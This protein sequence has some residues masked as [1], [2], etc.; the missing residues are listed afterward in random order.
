MRLDGIRVRNFR[1]LRRA[2]IDGLSSA[3]LVTVSGPNGSGK[4]LLFEALGFLARWWRP[5]PL[6]IDLS[7]LLGP[8]GTECEL[9]VTFSLAESERESL[10]KFAAITTW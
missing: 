2:E 9:V 1:G 5:P 10:S 7:Y 4:S 8:W 3:P 6:Q